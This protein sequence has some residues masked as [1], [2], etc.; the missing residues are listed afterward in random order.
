MPDKIR[1][2]LIFGGRSVEHEVSVITAYQALKALNRLKYEPVPIY[3]ARDNVWY[4]GQKLSD[5]SFLRNE[6]PSMQQLTRVF[7]SPDR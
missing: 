2:G 4:I 7:P 3:I 5:I 6:H 1:I